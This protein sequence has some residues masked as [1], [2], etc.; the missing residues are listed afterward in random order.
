[1][2]AAPQDELAALEWSLGAVMTLLIAVFSHV[3]LRLSRVEDKMERSTEAV[4]T[5]VRKA[6]DRFQDHRGRVLSDMVT[7]ADL[8]AAERRIMNAIRDRQPNHPQRGDLTSE[9]HG[10]D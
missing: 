1:M 3:Y 7:K 5:E 6:D 2:S 9:A 10:D 8:A 4:W